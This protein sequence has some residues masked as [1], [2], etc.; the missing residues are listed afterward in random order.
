MG[1]DE[2]VRRAEQEVLEAAREWD[3]QAQASGRPL[4]PVEQRLRMALF[5]LRKAKGLSGMHRISIPDGAD[6]ED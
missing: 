3:R 5:M 1:Q 4:T 2:I 6:P